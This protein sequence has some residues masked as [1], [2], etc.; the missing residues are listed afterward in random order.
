MFKSFSEWLSQ[1]SVTFSIGG[2]SKQPAILGEVATAVMY[3]VAKDLPESSEGTVKEFLQTD[4]DDHS[5]LEGLLNF[6]CEGL[7]ENVARKILSA[8]LY[9]LKDFDVEITG[10][11]KLDQSKMYG[12]KVYRIPV[13][14]VPP[15]DLPPELNLTNDNAFE[16][17]TMLG[18]P[19]QSYGSISVGELA[20]KLSGIT[21]FHIQMGMKAPS[22]ET[23]KRGAKVYD[24]GRSEDQINRY[25]ITLQ[26]MVQWAIDHGHD[27]I[28]FS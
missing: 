9:Y 25:L 1:M 28:N 7:A 15:Q 2:S 22:E 13:R 6:Y 20:T 24:M 14:M 11:P 10:T 8:I 17:L 18:M 5:E 16:L 21:D 4:G 12:G 19:N 26:K 27:T 3:K 23:G